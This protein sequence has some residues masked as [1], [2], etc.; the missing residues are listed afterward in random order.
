MSTPN[1]GDVTTQIVREDPRVEA[2]RLGLLGDVKEFIGNQINNPAALPPAI[3]IA[4][5]SGLEQQA[6]VLG[7]SGI[8]SYQPY[9]QNAMGY[10]GQSGNA[11]GQGMSSFNQAASQGAY[12]TQLGQSYAQAAANRL[13]NLAT[14]G[15]GQAIDPA[16]ARMQN[17]GYGLEGTGA[18]TASQLQNLAAGLPGA[19]Q[20]AQQGLQGSTLAGNQ[21][22]LAA[23]N[24]LAQASRSGQFAAD[25]SGRDL[26]QASMMGQAYAQAGG[27][28]ITDAT[29]AGQLAARQGQQTIGGAGQGL[30]GIGQQAYGDMRGLAGQY[31]GQTAQAQLGL[32]R[33]TLAAQQ[34]AAA[35]ARDIQDAGYMSSGIGTGAM[36]RLSNIAT[37]VTPQ[38]QASQQMS[39]TG[40]QFGMST[41][42]QGIA[43]LAGTGE[44]FDPSGISQFYNPFEQQAVDQALR[45]IQ[46]QGDIQQQNVAAQAV[47][48]G[49]FGGSREAVARQELQRNVM[50]QQGRTAAQMRQAG[51]SQAAQQAQQA[52]EQ[53]Q[54]RRQQAAQLTG[55]LGQAGAQALLQGGRDVGQIGLEGVKTEAGVVGQGAQLGLQGQQALMQSGQMAGQLGLSAAQQMAAN[56][57]QSG[58]LGYQGLQGQQSALAQGAQLGMQGQEGLMQSGQMAAQL[59]MTQAQQDALNAQRASELGMSAQ[60]MAAAN[61]AQRGQLGLSAAQQA[62]QFGLQ[63]GQIGLS[64]AQQAAANAAQSGQ[65]NLQQYQQLA[66]MYNQAGQSSM[67]GQQAALQAANMQGALGLQGVQQQGAL[68]QQAGQFGLEAGQM[69]MNYGNLL[70]QIGAQQG[71]L[72]QQYGTLGLQMAGLGELGQQLNL[73]DIQTLS[74]LG[75]QERAVQQAILDAQRQSTLQAQAF[76]YQQYAFLSDIYKGTPSSQQT[77]TTQATAQPSTFQQVAGL[78][79]AGLSAAAGAQQAGII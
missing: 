60:Q 77:M 62:G 22:A 30:A 4:G 51:Y 59:G 64:A 74:A 38:V 55:S 61:A 47:R 65:L 2:Y 79:I 46:R 20:G 5:L 7:A 28:R 21:S 52:F 33:A 39:G 68:T 50:E 75:G 19:M 71:Q 34:A 63:G 8:G 11:L 58:Q 54:A 26:D 43:S 17:L 44:Q 57:A 16:M 3:Q 23:Q 42:Q 49:A 66:N 32:D 69:G 24:A 73:R 27:R 29:L 56:A 18:L 12:G 78:G 13:G 67:A 31:G 10:M 15:V 76:P 37:G 45:D 36:N 41:A 1:Y 6:A 70:S 40:A 72:G 53:A 9:L 14:Q 48:S 25:L 35:G